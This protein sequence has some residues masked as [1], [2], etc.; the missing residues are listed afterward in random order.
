MKNT[1][2]LNRSWTG[3]VKSVE[4]QNKPI[5]DIIGFL[6]RDAST[7][8]PVVTLTIERSDGKTITKQHKLKKDQDQYAEALAAYYGLGTVVHRYKGAKYLKKEKNMLKIGSVAHRLCIICGN[9]DD[10]EHKNC[11]HCKSAFTE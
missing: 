3:L 6:D 8:I 1:A 9:F 5:N 7:T 4:R 10:F 2:I 11:R